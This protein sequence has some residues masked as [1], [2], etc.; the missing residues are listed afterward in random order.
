MVARDSSYIDLL[1]R[2]KKV[3]GENKISFSKEFIILL[4]DL[5]EKL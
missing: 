5:T 1:D 2:K 3:R 4:S